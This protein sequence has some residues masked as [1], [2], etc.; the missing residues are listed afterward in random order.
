MWARCGDQ[1]IESEKS[2]TPEPWAVQKEEEKEV[3]GGLP[4]FQP[5]AYIYRF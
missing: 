1:E 3:P 5:D 2:S 4:G